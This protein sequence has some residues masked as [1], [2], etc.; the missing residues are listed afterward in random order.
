MKKIL[1]SAAAI[2]ALAL[3]ASAATRTDV[4]VLEAVENIRTIS[5]SIAKDYL[6]LL[7]NPVKTETREKISGELAS[8]IKNIRTIS[9]STDD[10]DTKNLLEFLV[11][12]KNQL[13]ELLASTPDKEKAALVLD[14]SE[15]ILEG[16]QNIGAAHE[17]DFTE[18]EKQLMRTKRLEYLMERSAKY[19]MAYGAG[20][21]STAYAEEFQSTIEEIDREVAA[22][23]E[24][25]YTQEMNRP[26]KELGMYWASMQKFFNRKKDLFTPGLLILT[27]A[28]AE[29]TLETFAVYHRRGK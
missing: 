5:Q 26:E 24:H 14:Y 25:A 13:E 16:A 17:Y 18:S 8:L 22:L 19:Y 11:Y 10:E 9:M 12:S 15:T 1:L 6:Y 3:P 2:L 4:T 29:Q 27:S 23:Q 20:I 28:G 21:D 7:V